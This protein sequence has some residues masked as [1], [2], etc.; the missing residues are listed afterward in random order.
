MKTN[1]VVKEMSL[2][3][4][5]DRLLLERAELDKMRLAHTVSPIENP[6]RITEHKRNIARILTELHKRK[7]VEVKTK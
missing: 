5:K 3:E 4:L 7:T 2:I 6:H 1:F